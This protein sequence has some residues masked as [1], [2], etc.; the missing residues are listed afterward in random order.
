MGMG[1][2]QVREYVRMLGGRVEVQST[3]GKGT[4]FSISLPAVNPQASRSD[5]ANHAERVLS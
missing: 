4:R 1:A 5:A 3:P 2:Y